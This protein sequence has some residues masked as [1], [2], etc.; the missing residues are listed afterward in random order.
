[1]EPYALGYDNK[2]SLIVLFNKFNIWRL[3]LDKAI[4]DP[5]GQYWQRLPPALNYGNYFSYGM[6]YLMKGDNIMLF[7]DPY[8]LVL[9]YDL[10]NIVWNM[11][12]NRVEDTRKEAYVVIDN[13]ELY[14]IGGSTGY[15]DTTTYQGDRFIVNSDIC[16]FGIGTPV[17]PRLIVQRNLVIGFDINNNMVS[18]FVRKQGTFDK[19]WAFPNYY[20]VERILVSVD[21]DSLEFTEEMEIYIRTPDGIERPATYSVKA[22]EPWS[23]N[24]YIRIYDN[25]RA[26]TMY[27]DQYLA[28][29]IYGYIAE[30]QVYFRP[31]IKDYGYVARVNQVFVVPK[32][33]EKLTSTDYY[34]ACEDEINIGIN[35]TMSEQKYITATTDDKDLSISWNG[36]EYSDKDDTLIA[37]RTQLTL[38]LKALHR[39][40]VTHLMVIND[41]SKE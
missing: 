22:V 19:T 20:Y 8:G 13:A 16:E 10:E 41:K 30:F 40:K 24:E 23:F 4:Y 38:R 7:V 28:V 35:N 12:R 27:P 29:D 37:P 14:Y 11:V 3:D 34:V 36:F 5:N 31:P 2:Y 18:A 33:S 32:R 6:R 15:F 39:G 21:Y 9:S 17:V 1:M 26:R 25:G